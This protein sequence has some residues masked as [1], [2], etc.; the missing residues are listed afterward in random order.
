MIQFYETIIHYGN[1]KVAVCLGL[2]RVR[3]IVHTAK[4][5]FVVCQ[6]ENT[7]KTKHEQQLELLSCVGQR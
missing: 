6:M 4:I 1:G 5:V 2:C 3:N 7:R